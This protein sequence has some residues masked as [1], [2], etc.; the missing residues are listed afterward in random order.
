MIEVVRKS[1][2]GLEAEIW[3]FDSFRGWFVLREYMRGSRET[4]RHKFRGPK[5]DS[6]DERRP[7]SQLERPT[8]IPADV[9]EE[10][11]ALHHQKHIPVTIGWSGNS[12]RIGYLQKGKFY[13]DRSAE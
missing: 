2:N 6:S 1:D 12:C 11:H 4:T 3:R 8:E 9:V 7:N 5:W 13:P 10:A